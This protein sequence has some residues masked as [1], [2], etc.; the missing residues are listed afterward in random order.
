MPEHPAWLDDSPA[1]EAADAAI[2]NSQQHCRLTDLHGP[3]C[4]LIC[5]GFRSHF[6]YLVYFFLFQFNYPAIESRT[7]IVFKVPKG[8]KTGLLWGAKTGRN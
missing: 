2:G 4:G 3:L 1:D 7:P 5:I 8:A 6:F